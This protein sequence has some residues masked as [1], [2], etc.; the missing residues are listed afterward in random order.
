M[1]ATGDSTPFYYYQD[2]KIYLNV[3]QSRVVVSTTH[4]IDP[5]SAATT[6]AR[7]V[8]A[9]SGVM[10]DS[11]KP[12]MQ[13]PDHAVVYLTK[14]ASP[15]AT[16]ALRTALTK[17]ARFRFVSPVY[18][19]QVGGSAIIPL[20]R[21][22]VRFRP[23]VSG[24]QAMALADSMGLTLER[25]PKPDSGFSAYWFTYPS[26]PSTNTLA[27]AAQLDHN[28]LVSWAD[29]DR[30]DNGRLDAVP[31]DPYFPY[32]DYLKNSTL[33]NGVPVDIN[34][35]PAWE[36]TTGSSTIRVAIIGS[37]VQQAH[38]EL[39]SALVG[40]YDS[41]AGLP[42]IPAGEDAY[43]P[44]LTCFNPAENETGDAH[45]TA[46]A[47]ILAARQ[48]MDREPVVSRRTSTSLSRAFSATTWKTP[49]RTSQMPSTGRGTPHT[50]M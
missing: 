37:G 31:T 35:E 49:R 20:D 11:V 4:G 47:E 6:D 16:S 42:G 24:A 25:T 13:A 12:L 22:V 41:F 19:L 10:L 44:C 39:G 27:I 48:T 38:P 30:I 14:A 50:P 21:V 23:N 8:L 40:G 3:D 45:G 15:A 17:D 28:S 34:V 2:Q 5:V 36:L 18:T 1:V 26:N 9:A 46:V 32:Q 43:H 7:S 33:L 29:P